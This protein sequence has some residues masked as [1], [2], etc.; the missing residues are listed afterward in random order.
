MDQAP[1]PTKL[2]TPLV[3]SFYAA[4][5]FVAVVLAAFTE[6]GLALLS[7]PPS[8]T[9]ALPGDIPL[10]WWV[11]GLATG[12]LL[13]AVSRLAERL[14]PAMRRLA[15][16]LSATL[17][18][19]S[20]GQALIW[21]AAS[22]LAEEALFRGSVQYGLG[23]VPA[24]L[25]FALL[26]GG[27]SRRLVAWSTFALLAGLSFGLL[28]EAFG[29]IWPAVVAHVVVNAINLRRLGRSDQASASA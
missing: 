6:P 19:V 10:P 24:S 12:L 13:V 22:G 9:R 3:L 25:I 4:M 8:L 2:T 11:A 28:V 18:P 21:A 15:R 14:W 20:V 5:L 16:E 1:E 26:H 29:S 17:G 27:L 7:A 23:Y